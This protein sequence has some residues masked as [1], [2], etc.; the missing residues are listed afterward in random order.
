MIVY[1]DTSFL[2]SFFYE[3]DSNHKAARNLAARFDGHDF[4]LCQ[5]HQLELPAA[6][7][8]ATHREESPVS[9]PVARLI[10]NRFERAWNGGMF[11][12]RNLPLE[13]SI[14]MARSLGEAH[15]WTRRHTAFDLWHLGAAWAMGA[16]AFLTFDERQKELCKTMSLRTA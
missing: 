5:L 3:H 6:L 8:A 12:R 10:I 15:G 7:R 1:S 16:A 2:V 4:A 11:V 13:E 14:N 9:K